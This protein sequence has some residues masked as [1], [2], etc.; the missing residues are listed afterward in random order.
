LPVTS[1]AVAVTFAEKLKELRE[2][3]Q[4]S[5]AGLSRASG[6]S[7]SAIHDY[8]QG[9]REPSL[10]SAVKIAAALGTDCRAFADCTEEEEKPKAKKRK[11]K[12]KP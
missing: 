11:G 7:L 9:K 12:G 5:Q 6:M 8:E 10:R 1:E 3:A 4:I 2:K